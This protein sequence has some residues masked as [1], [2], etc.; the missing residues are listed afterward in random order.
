MYL[1]RAVAT[2]RQSGFEMTV[3]SAGTARF[4]ED[5][6]TAAELLRQ[7]NERLYAEKKR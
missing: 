1:E 3:A 4:P 6:T 2:P 5:A 7:S